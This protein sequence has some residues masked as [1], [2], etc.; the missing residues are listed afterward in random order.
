VALVCGLMSLLNTSIN[1]KPVFVSEV[2]TY[3][4]PVIATSF[5]KERPSR[6]ARLFCSLVLFQAEVSFQL[7][8]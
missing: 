4:N 8:I 6:V 7:T 3:K 1:K 2:V 5:Y